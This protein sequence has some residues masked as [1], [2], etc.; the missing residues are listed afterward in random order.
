V[1]L[2]V[3]ITP[4]GSWHDT[5]YGHHDV[6][7]PRL[8][9]RLQLPG[10]LN[11]LT[12]FG[13]GPGEAYVDSHAAAQLGRWALPID[14]LA[15]EYPFPQENGNRHQVR[16]A[17]LTGPG[18]PGLRVDAASAI[19]ITVRRCTNHDLDA[20]RKPYEIPRRDATYLH[21]DHA[22]RGLGSSSVGPALPERYEIPIERT[23]YAVVLT[24]TYPAE[25]VSKV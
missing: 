20:A 15:V 14:E 21:V 18:M 3:D 5:P 7:L 25:D 1:R 23:R 2:T 13:L 22:V 12:W 9:V 8:G 10:G 16:W 17:E 11:D 24:I 6:V 4:T 19:D